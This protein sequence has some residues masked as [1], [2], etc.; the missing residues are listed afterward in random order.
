MKLGMNH[1]EAKRAVQQKYFGYVDDNKCLFVF[2]GRIVEQKGVHL[3]I[4]C[5]EMLHNQYGGAFQFIVGGQAAPDDRSYGFPVTQRM[6]DLR[7]RFPGNFWADPSQFFADG[8]LACHAADYTLIPSMFEP[9]GI[10]QQEA[11]ASGCPVIAFRTGGLADTVFEFD[12]EKRTG[13]GFLFWAF[14]HHDY[15]MAIQRAYDIFRDKPQYWKLRE[16]AYN[17]VL[18]TEKV[19]VQ[20]SREFA[21]M[22]LKIFDN[23]KE[24]EKEEAAAKAKQIE[25]E[26]VKSKQ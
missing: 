1:D 22:F 25:I 23:V 10:V 18:T 7:N 13:N 3:I 5:F 15:L 20:W 4:D 14:Q 26:K 9:S 11:F 16:N 19:A 24:R 2:V 6:W 12:R 21:R 8:L 17:S